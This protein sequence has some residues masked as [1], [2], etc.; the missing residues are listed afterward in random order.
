MIPNLAF[1]VTRSTDGNRI[2][3]RV[4]DFAID[5][6]SLVDAGLIPSTNGCRAALSSSDLN[7]FIALGKEYH[8]R[9]Y[10]ELFNLRSKQADELIVRGSVADG[11][12]LSK[13]LNPGDFVD[14]Y[15]NRFHAARSARLT[16]NPDFLS[17]AW[18]WMPQCYHGRTAGIVGSGSSICRPSGWMKDKADWARSSS[19]GLDFEI[20]LGFVL[21]RSTLPGERL[22]PSEFEDA[23]FG[24]VVV[25]DWSARDLQSA[26]AK[27]LGP[28]HAK[29]F[30]T[31]IGN[32]VMPIECLSQV[33]RSP[34]DI[35]PDGRSPV[36]GSL[37]DIGF[38]AYLSSAESEWV[39]VARTN[40][41]DMAWT[42]AEMMAHLAE[43]GAP[44][45]VGD[46][47]ASGTISGRGPEALGCLV[48]RMA[49]GLPSLT[50]SD[51]SKRTFLRDGDTLRVSASLDQSGNQ[52]RLDEVEGTIVPSKFALETVA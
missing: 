38:E 34:G 11:I 15:A 48:E 50:L 25:I 9:V 23:V 5:L 46:L 51:G 32:W 22:D 12:A 10:E 16:G 1:G 52:I 37:Y 13:P 45:R 7:A 6:L 44:V 36:V 30:A 3:A 35:R 29:A 26:E 19:R 18:D 42:P 21:R 43:S 33:Q 49:E 14:F 31:Q 40:L 28:F 20:E 41:R 24:C 2:V 47:F 8:A 17:E 27:P 39:K 4:D